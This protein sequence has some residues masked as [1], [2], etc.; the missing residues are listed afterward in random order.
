MTVAACD[1]KTC[2]DPGAPATPTSPAPATVRPGSTASLHPNP[3][4][5]SVVLRF[6]QLANLLR[7]TRQL[8]AADTSPTAVDR[9][10][11]EAQSLLDLLRSQVIR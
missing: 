8:A 1:D 2:A 10:L 3:D 11:G 4:H 6:D 5:D 7:V 9:M